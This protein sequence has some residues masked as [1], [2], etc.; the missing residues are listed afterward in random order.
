MTIVQSNYSMLQQHIFYGTITGINGEVPWSK[1]DI[2][3]K[4]TE[5][6]YKFYAGIIHK[7]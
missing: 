1:G 5:R 3:L 6:K 7:F 2:Q 4:C